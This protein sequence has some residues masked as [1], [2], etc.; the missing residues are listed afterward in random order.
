MTKIAQYT[1][2]KA[3]Y[4]ATRKREIQSLCKLAKAFSVEKLLIITLD[5]AETIRQENHNIQV[6]PVWK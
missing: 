2:Q 4:P 6:M 3:I 5:E 1:K